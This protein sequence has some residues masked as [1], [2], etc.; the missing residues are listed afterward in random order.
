MTNNIKKFRET[1]KLTQEQ[2]SEKIDVTRKTICSW[3]RGKSSPNAEHLTKLTEVLHVNA[4]E[5]IEFCTPEGNPM[6]M[7][8]FNIE[9]SNFTSFKW[10]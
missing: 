9:V 7:I 10:I 3:E 4:N 2:L 5:I 6:E 8:C 1:L